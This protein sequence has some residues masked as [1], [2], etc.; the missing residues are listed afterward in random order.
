MTAR[1]RFDAIS[2]LV[3]AGTGLHP[4]DVT[5]GSR[6]PA[7][8]RPRQLLCWLAWRWTALSQVAIGQ[9]IGR[10]PTSVGA[11]IRRVDAG[12]DGRL[13]ARARRLEVALRARGWRAPPCKARLHGDGRGDPPWAG[14][15]L[16]EAFAEAGR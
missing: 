5:E 4:G 2:E 13:M 8:T 1:D 9:R 7:T 12:R 11:A 16:A 10:D 3:T 6:H 15:P 14:D